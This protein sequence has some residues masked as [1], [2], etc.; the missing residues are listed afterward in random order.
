MASPVLPE[1]ALYQPMPKQETDPEREAVKTSKR[2]RLRH[3][4]KIAPDPTILAREKLLC[5]LCNEF[6]PPGENF[7]IYFDHRMLLAT[8][9]CMQ[10]RA[11]DPRRDWLFLI[12]KETV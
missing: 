1:T 8:V 11:E 5:G 9:N 12:V 4:Q 3:L 7:A 6:I 2:A 10:C